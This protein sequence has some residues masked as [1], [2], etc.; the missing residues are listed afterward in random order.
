MKSFKQF[1]LIK[2]SDAKGERDGVAEEKSSN[3]KKE[4]EHISLPKGFIPPSKMRPVIRAFDKSKD[5]IVHDDLSKPATMPKKTLYLTGGAVRDFVKG[6]SL[7]D[8]HLA[9]NATP[10]QVGQ[11][12]SGAGFKYSG[13]KSGKDGEFNVPKKVKYSGKEKK[14][15]VKVDHSDG[16]DYMTWWVDE[17]D[18]SA[19]KKAFAI[20]AKVGDEV[21]KIETFRKDIDVIDGQAAEVDFVDNPKED[22]DRRDLTF[23]AMYIPLEKADKENKKLYDFHGGYEDSKKGATNTVGDAKDKFQEDPIRAFRAIRFHCRFGDNSE[24]DPEIKKAIEKFLDS[25]LSNKTSQVKEIKKEFEKALKHDEIDPKCYIEILKQTG[26]LKVLFPGVEFDPPSGIPDEISSERDKVLQVAWLLQ[27][28]SESDIEKVLGGDSPSDAIDSRA[29]RFLLDLRNYS[30][31]KVYDSIKSIKGTGLDPVQ[32]EKWMKMFQNGSRSLP[33]EV[34][35][36]NDYIKKNKGDTVSSWEDAQEA[37][38]DFCPHCQDGI[39]RGQ[40]CGSCEGGGLLPLKY[41]QDAVKEMERRS[42]LD[43]AKG[44]D[45]I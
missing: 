3:W 18:N 8:Y 24:L 31:D 35:K 29:V 34:G 28:N 44:C 25:E 11:I 37:G 38:L 16:D 17:R 33:A 10:E 45:E 36:F 22:A 7:N 26:L 4:T 12:L 9:T 15:D 43:F 27:H 40:L 2:E 1:V 42:I 41:R 30:H 32:L 6:K 20:G 5:I 13:D 14:D 23:N 21:F 19:D 39:Y